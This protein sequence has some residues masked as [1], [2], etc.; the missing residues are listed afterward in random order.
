[1]RS[2]LIAAAIAL[3]IASRLSAAP[4][5]KGPKPD[6]GDGHLAWFDITTT[7]LIQSKAFYNGLFGWEFT[8][9]KGYEELAAEIVSGGKAIG[10]LRKA[11]GKISPFDGVV[12][13][14][15]KDLAASCAKAKDLG[16]A[17]APGFPFDLEDGRGA[18]ALLIDPAG[19]PIGMYSR[20]QL[21]KAK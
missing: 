10:S 8:S 5:Q 13:I 15:V 3:A 20:T 4:E 18:I 9:V 6:V 11:E 16:A 21:P 14:Q 1:M 7:N 17:I 19:H 2:R 12:Y